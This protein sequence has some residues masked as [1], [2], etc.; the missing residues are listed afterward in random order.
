MRAARD[1]LE[2]EL[3]AR[4]GERAE[5]YVTTVKPAMAALRYVHSGAKDGRHERQG[6][7]EEG[8]GAEEGDAAADVMN[9]MLTPAATHTNAVLTEPFKDELSDK[10]VGDLG[11]M[12]KVWSLTKQSKRDEKRRRVE[13]AKRKAG[14]AE[15]E[16]NEMVAAWDRERRIRRQQQADAARA[17]MATR[18][19]Q[20]ATTVENHDSIGAKVSLVQRNQDSTSATATRGTN[21]TN[22]SADDGLPTALM[23]V[24][25]ERWPVKLDSGARYSVAGTDWMQRGERLRKTAPVE[26]VEGIGGFLLDVIGVW[27]FTMRNAFGQTVEVEACIIDECTDE[28]LIGVDFMRSHKANMDFARNEVRYCAH[29]TEV[30]IPFRT[31]GTDGEAKVAA[32]RLVKRTRLAQSAVTPIEVT[33]AA[34]D[35]EEG[36]FV[37]S[38]RCGTVMLATTVTRAKDGKVLVPAINVQGGKVKLPAKKELGTWV[39]IDDDM[40]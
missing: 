4:D 16:V 9:G 25:N 28:F 29:N 1:E 36:I 26:H 17:E 22:V 11:S 35:G 38:R 5:R 23:A 32:V 10:L 33:V 37:P 2:S 7:R 6:R 20:R 21:E 19:K 24:D 13:N 18:R 3:A 8:A 15:A 34:R 12:A 40:K 31:E 27:A 14:D 39:P 30:V